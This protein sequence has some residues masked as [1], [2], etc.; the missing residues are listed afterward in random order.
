MRT[1]FALTAAAVLTT[2]ATAATTH[3]H[4]A[5]PE[6]GSAAVRELNEKSLQQASAGG[7]APGAAPMSDASQMAAAAPMSA[8][9]PADPA[10]PAD[11]AMPA[12]PQ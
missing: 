2:A 4:M 1:I 11:P 7:T 10:T 12:P 9:A 3:R 6:T 5:K 8:P